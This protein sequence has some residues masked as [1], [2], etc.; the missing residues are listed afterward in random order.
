[1]KKILPAFCLITLWFLVSCNQI[2]VASSAK[3]D[4]LKFLEA[5]K[6]NDTEKILTYAPFL[7]KSNS[8][9]K[10][11]ANAFFSMLSDSKIR[12]IEKR[13]D[14]RSAALT[15]YPSNE[16]ITHTIYVEKNSEGNW[17]ILPTWTNTKTI[18]KISL[19]D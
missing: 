12:V 2:S 15:I 7:E 8:E 14:T 18:D 19:D 3:K 10:E 5:Y 17:I 6:A 9:Q 4:F 1:M 13:I 16:S 11:A